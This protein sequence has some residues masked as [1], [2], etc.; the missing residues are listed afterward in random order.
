M[1]THNKPSNSF[2]GTE[3]P[4]LVFGIAGRIGS[5][6]SFVTQV[7]MEEIKAFG[8]KPVEIKVT[9]QFLK[10]D[11]CCSANLESSACSTIKDILR[12]ISDNNK[13]ENKQRSEKAQRIIDLQAKGNKLRKKSGRND[14]IA[15]LSIYYI[16]EKLRQQN[17]LNEG[18]GRYAYIIDSL[19]HPEEVKL[20]KEVF[21]ASFYMIGAVANDSVRKRRLQ[22]QKQITD[23]E[24]KEISEIDSGEKIIMDSRQQKQSKN[25]ITFSRTITIHQKRLIKNVKDY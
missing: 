7:M 10:K 2:M 20:L 22:D 3:T 14:I 13:L 25:L 9:D 23:S 15:A 5:G 17:A 6:A 11:Y 24:F 4:I 19:K 16:A 18:E 12:I 21:G 1:N 8:Y